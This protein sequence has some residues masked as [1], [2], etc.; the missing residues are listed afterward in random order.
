MGTLGDYQG[1]STG[2]VDAT[3]A[4]LALLARQV[5]VR[6]PYLSRLVIVYG[7]LAAVYLHV[8]AASR[9][10][11]RRIR[12]WETREPRNATMAS[13][14]PRV[15]EADG[16]IDNDWARRQLPVV[17]DTRKLQARCTALHCIPT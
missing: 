12:A 8:Q 4:Y 14:D 16:A 3:M 11:V 17:V 2:L 7:V 10:Q 6:S 13:I 9:L 15:T 1:S 5:L